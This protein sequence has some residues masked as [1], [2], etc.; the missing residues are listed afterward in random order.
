[1]NSLY[2][3]IWK[4]NESDEEYSIAYQLDEDG[5]QAVIDYLTDEGFSGS[6][7]VPM[8][9]FKGELADI[10]ND[11]LTNVE[12]LSGMASDVHRRFFIMFLPTLLLISTLFVF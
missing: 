1:M 9:D 11:T 5:T 2:A 12:V 10:G 6:D 7:K 3:L 8:L 4:E